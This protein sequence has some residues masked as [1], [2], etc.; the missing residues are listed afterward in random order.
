[1]PATSTIILSVNTREGLTR[2]DKRG[3]CWQASHKPFV[4]FFIFSLFIGSG[5]QTVEKS[6]RWHGFKDTARAF[7]HGELTA[8]HEPSAEAVY[9]IPGVKGEPLVVK[10]YEDK[11]GTKKADKSGATKNTSRRY[12]LKLYL[13]TLES[14]EGKGWAGRTTALRPFGGVLPEAV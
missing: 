3:S 13:Y 1:M 7:N 4:G 6:K 10:S 14:Y 8:S 11:G 2:P 12:S 5:G 9:L